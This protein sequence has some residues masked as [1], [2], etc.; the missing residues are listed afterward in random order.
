MYGLAGPNLFRRGCPETGGIAAQIHGWLRRPCRTGDPNTRL[1]FRR[2]S[3]SS[4]WKISS[5]TLRCHQ[6]KLHGG[7]V[8][9]LGAIW[10]SSPTK[11]PPVGRSFCHQKCEGIG[12]SSGDFASLL[13]KVFRRRNP[14][15]VEKL[16]H[17][18]P[19]R[20]RL[21]LSKFRVQFGKPFKVAVDRR[22]GY[23]QCS[24]RCR[25]PFHLLA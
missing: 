20:W 17:Q 9:L 16:P 25:H 19:S 11:H 15:R 7:C 8:P 21:E 2:V 10:T 3:R 6:R 13:G 24:C 1:S 12:A 5:R 4:Y 23:S 18:W 14:Q 22:V